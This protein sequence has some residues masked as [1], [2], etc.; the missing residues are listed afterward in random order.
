M[1]IWNVLVYGMDGSIDDG[2]N[3]V[4]PSDTGHRIS[5]MCSWN[6]SKPADLGAAPMNN[7]VDIRSKQ[8]QMRLLPYHP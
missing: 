8:R 1:I 3:A 4:T 2:L 7:V 6:A 5:F